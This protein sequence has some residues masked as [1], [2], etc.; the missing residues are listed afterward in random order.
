MTDTLDVLLSRSSI[1]ALLDPPPS[2][3]MLDRILEAA[4]RAPDHGR[5]RPWRFVLVRGDARAA[6]AAVVADAGRRRDPAAPDVFVE[7]QRN[8]FLRTPLVIALGARVVPSDKIPEVE[9]LM[10]LGAAAMNL[11]NA[12][13]AAGF[14]GVWITGAT[15]YD[16]TVA[17]AL[18][19]RAPDRLLGFLLVGTPAVSDRSVSPRPALG[20]HVTDWTAPTA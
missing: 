7:K 19:L 18:G 14:G 1:G 6:F 11:L 16:P 10:S 8:K 12:I 13:H 4:L 15:A 17:E 5:L 9:Q 20:D 2:G 3:P